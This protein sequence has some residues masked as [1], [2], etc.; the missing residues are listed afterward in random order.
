VAHTALG[1]YIER[2]NAIGATPATIDLMLHPPPLM[3]SQ[4][5]IESIAY[6]NQTG[7]ETNL[8]AH[9]KSFSAPEEEY[10]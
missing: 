1:E 6:C 10:P 9:G 8:L 7:P 5:T 3:N 2:I 4:R